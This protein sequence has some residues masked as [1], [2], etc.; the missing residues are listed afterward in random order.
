MPII[1]VAADPVREEVAK[2]ERQKQRALEKLES[3]ARKGIALKR[4]V[5]FV[6]G[7][8]G[9]HGK[10]WTGY[11]GKLLK[12]HASVKS[13][14][15]KIVRNPE[16]VTYVN[17]LEFS[18]KESSVSKSFLDFGELLKAK[19]RG[20]ATEA[21]PIDLIGHSMGGLDIL[22]AI[23]QGKDALTNVENCVAVASPLRGIVYSQFVKFAD[24]LL[25]G[26]KWE[27]YHYVQ[28]RNL[29]TTCAAIR[30][31]NLPENRRK[32]LERVKAFYHLEGTQDP[33]IM[34]SARLR[35]DGIPEQFKAK[36]QGLPVEGASHSGAAGIT[37]NP[38]TV[39]HLIS[40]IAD[41]PI[42]KPSGN[43]GYVYVRKGGQGQE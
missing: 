15:E 9:E 43:K 10:A 20:K 16:R 31:V 32:L 7:W 1:P 41:I 42:E 2:R 38:Q 39:L 27:P 22:A 30:L 5:F 23:T 8:A 11:D 36:V 25:P 37:H 33:T 40:I 18:D 13:W 19:V 26:M 3:L 28:V 24:D 6:P 21:L 35:T 17:Y 12:G 14:V 34:R 4:H 29:A